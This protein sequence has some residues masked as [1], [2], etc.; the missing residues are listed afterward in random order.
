[1]TEQKVRAAIK[2]VVDYITTTADSVGQ[3]SVVDV[4]NLF[5]AL[6]KKI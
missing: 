5:R 2:K 1:M 6:I 3:V 4:W